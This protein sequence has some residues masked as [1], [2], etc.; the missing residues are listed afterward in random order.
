MIDL[1]Y[2]HGC[3]I[4]KLITICDYRSILTIVLLTTIQ[5]RSILSFVAFK[6]ILFNSY[7]FYIFHINACRINNSIVIYKYI[8]RYLH[9]CILNEIVVPLLLQ[10]FFQIKIDLLF[11]FN[12]NASSLISTIVSKCVANYFQYT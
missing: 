2:L 12:I 8:I 10:K 4:D 7:H 1:A 6:S 5:T 9:C 11:A 3:I